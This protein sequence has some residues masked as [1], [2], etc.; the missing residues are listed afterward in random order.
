ML[1]DEMQVRSRSE[2]YLEQV[3]ANL[4]HTNEQLAHYRL[5][6]DKLMNE[7][8]RLKKELLIRRP[9][10]QQEERELKLPQGSLANLSAIE[11]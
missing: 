4:E 3:P 10:A 8:I 2:R 5:E 1:R 6:V 7:N 11:E 9:E